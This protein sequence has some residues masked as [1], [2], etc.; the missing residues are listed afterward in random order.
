MELDVA[1]RSAY[2]DQVCTDDSSLRREVESLLVHEDAASTFLDPP[3][4]TGAAVTGVIAS[5]HALVGR[6]FGPYTVLAPIGAGGMGEVYRAR[7]E[8]LGRHVAI[9]V[10]PPHFSSDHDRRA[11]L[12]SEAR[13]LAAV[14]HPHISAI[15]GIEEVDGCP[16]LVLELVEGETLAERL[17]RSPVRLAEALA[18]ARQ[19]AIVE[20]WLEEL[21]TR[22]P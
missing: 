12:E 16:A 6:R 8:Q 1:K 3:A 7:D 13:I 14:N 2:L 11:R 22:V 18:I 20:H 17:A 4:F 15:Y 9:K 21:K 5:Q 19:I 10:L